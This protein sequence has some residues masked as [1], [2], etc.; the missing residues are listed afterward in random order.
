[1]QNLFA[2]LIKKCLLFFKP[3]L[4]W[5]FLQNEA[6]IINHQAIVKDQS[7]S[8]MVDT[9]NVWHR[10]IYLP[11]FK[12]VQYLADDISK[13]KAVTGPTVFI[14]KNK[15]QLEYHYFN[16]LFLKEKI[17]SI[18]YAN[19]SMT[20]HWLPFNRLW[21]WCVLRL[22]AFY[23]NPAQEVFDEKKHIA[24][25]FEKGRNALLNLVIS[26]DYLFGL[27]KTDPLD[28]LKPLIEIQKTFD[29]PIHVV[30]L[31]FIYDKHPQKVEKTYFDLLFGEKSNPGAVR[32]FLLFILKYR[33]QP[34]VKFGDPLNL[35]EFIQQRADVN[36]THQGTALLRHIE[37]NLRIEHARMTGP[38]LMSKDARLEEIMGD[39]TFVDELK[40]MAIEDNTN[41]DEYTARAARY[42]QEIAA[43]VNYSYIHFAHVTLKYLW[44]R[45]FDG[46]VVKHD[47]LDKVRN[48]A[49]KNPVI[50]VPMH[51]SHIDYLLISDLF[52]MH[53]ITFP[54]V[55]AGI[56]MN[57]WPVG[58]IARKCGAF[59]IRRSFGGDRLYKETLYRYIKS[60]A[61]SGHC[62][63]FFIEGTRS[64]TGK[65]LK[66]KMGIL[67]M[68]MRAFFEGAC[69]DVYFVPIAVNYDH[70]L[71]QKAYQE[72]GEGADKSRENAGELLKTRRIF[73]KR[74]GKVYI[75]FADPVS[76]REY[77]RTHDVAAASTDAAVLLKREAGGFASHLTYHMNKVAV[78]TPTALVS[79][80]IMSFASRTFNAE[81]LDRRIKL[82]K[83]YLDFKEVEYSD[84]INFSD[85]YAY[86]EAI[87]RFVAQGI[88][89]EMETFEDRFYMFED[90]YRQNL[91]YYKNN[92]LHFFVSLVCFCKI[93]NTY[94]NHAEFYLETAVKQHENIRKILKHDF[95]FSTRQP[96]KQH[97]LRVIDFCVQCGFISFDE[98]SLKITKRLTNAVFDDFCAY[99]GLLDNFLESHL[100]GLK[101]IKHKK[102]ERLEK[103]AL[104]KEILIKARPMY[105]Q[106]SLKHPEALSRFNLENSFDCFVDLGILKCDNDKGRG[107][108]T[109]TNDAVL[110]D[111]WIATLDKML[112][113]L[114]PLGGAQ[115]PVA[116]SAEGV[117]EQDGWH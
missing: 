66:P 105:L 3:V 75:E 71:E 27:I 92:I 108:F 1:M 35:A 81:T 2:M 31:Q 77:C 67:S 82:L 100:I 29:S 24:S 102:I 21:S 106:G 79:T 28:V 23:E 42:L 84:L 7:L 72:E 101:F 61:T 87:K 90:K 69:E 11:F 37:D 89:K 76:L 78:V 65:M 10:W 20:I 26:R 25:V 15:G 30:T 6:K 114:L 83:D 40:K 96:L 48:I 109:A 94:E 53:N 107:Y 63:E 57:F 50:L 13:I 104:I 14:M 70:L 45:V 55:C 39:Q 103:K 32:K 73:N 4:E 59:F 111:S 116:A 93:L 34:R 54:H 18:Y 9:F 110:V 97:L 49:G 44:D 113:V 115:I 17:P 8:G 47:Q 58:R 85:Q 33:G 12:R 112:K 80:A 98:G 38:K 68:V 36:E 91:D 22:K 99:Q 64:R 86:A 19:K 60:L 16:H 88:L 62:I 41:P 52:Y 46:L 95:T 117:S 74:Y 51:R 43:D 56:N 5:L